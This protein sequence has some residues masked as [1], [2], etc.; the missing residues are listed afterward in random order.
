MKLSLCF[1]YQNFSIPCS[2]V[3]CP[4]A[5]PF[6]KLEIVK[7]TFM[8]GKFNGYGVIAAIFVVVFTIIASFIYGLLLRINKNRKGMN[9]FLEKSSFP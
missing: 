5:C 8:I 6:T 2:C 9:N 1:F 3:D 4:T 7:D